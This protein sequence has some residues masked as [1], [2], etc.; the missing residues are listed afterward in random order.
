MTKY[1]INGET[2]VELAEAKDA[3]IVHLSVDDKDIIVSGGQTI[4][5]ALQRMP[6]IGEIPGAL[7]Q[8]GGAAIRGLP[9]VHRGGQR[10]RR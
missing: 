1:W 3:N 8:P 5:E 2:A 10:E 7:L 9:A 6:G 4:F